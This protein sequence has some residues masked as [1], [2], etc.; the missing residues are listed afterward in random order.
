MK[1]YT[2]TGDRGKTSL[3]SGERVVKSHIRVEAYGDVDELNAVLG[4][5]VSDM[6]G[7]SYGEMIAQLQRIQSDLFHISALLATTPGSSAAGDLAAVEGS[8]VRGLEQFIDQM[9]ETLP[10]LR[11]FI[12]PGGSKTASWAHIARTVCRRSERHVIQMLDETSGGKM[13]DSYETVV[14]YLNRLSDYLFVLSRCCNSLENIP[15]IPWE[16][17]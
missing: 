11:G 15:D 6:S 17:G 7:E 14:A 1:I 3:F 13:P 9:E 4:A 8:S 12:L 5:L 10:P 16:R 2:Q